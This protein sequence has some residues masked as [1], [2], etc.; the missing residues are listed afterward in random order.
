[1]AAGITTILNHKAQDTFTSQ[2]LQQTGML[3]NQANL[4]DVGL[5]IA[6]IFGG[7]L[8]QQSAMV[9][10]MPIQKGARHSSAII[11][12]GESVMGK[13][14]L[15]SAKNNTPLNECFVSDIALLTKY[16]M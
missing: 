10:R 13:S 7:A 15:N 8:L 16:L 4:C 12:E 9:C 6:G 14:S 11:C 2:F 1:M 3:Q 5:S